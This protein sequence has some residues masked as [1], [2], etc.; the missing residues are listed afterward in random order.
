MDAVQGDDPEARQQ[1]LNEITEVF[2]T[3]NKV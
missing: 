2:E 3:A 1:V